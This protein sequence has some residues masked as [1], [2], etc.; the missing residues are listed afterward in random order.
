MS[1]RYRGGLCVL[2]AGLLFFAPQDGCGAQGQPDAFI[3]K[4][5]SFIKNTATL[6]ASSDSALEELARQLRA[7][8]SVSIEIRCATG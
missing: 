8:P 1:L 2:V 5:V 6:E 3:L 4:G 7:D